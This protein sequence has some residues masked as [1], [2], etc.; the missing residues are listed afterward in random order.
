MIR[1]IVLFKLL[2]ET[3]EATIQTHMADF[4]ALETKVPA[5]REIMVQRD[6]VGRDVSADFGLVVSF[7]DDAALKAYGAHPEH[8]AAFARLK[9][10]LDRMLVL[11]YAE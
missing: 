8:Q 10:R 4:R 9:P 7:D 5:I 2:T 11:D 6:I 1:H 3:D